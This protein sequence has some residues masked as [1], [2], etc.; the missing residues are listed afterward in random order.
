[1]TT[2]TSERT[3]AAAAPAGRRTVASYAT[4]QEAE[5]A[6]D[7]LAENGFPV[8]R[9]AI[10]GRELEY[11]EQVTGKTGYGDAAIRGAVVG[12]LTGLL[13]GWLFALFNW[14]DP[15]VSPGWLVIDGLW[16]GLV[17]GA[18]SGVIAHAILRGRR[19]FDSVPA[20]R[21]GSYEVI[22]DEEVADEAKRLLERGSDPVD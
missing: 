12:G 22:A 13:I 14:F 7:R 21:A 6:V 5:R 3:N 1:M 16:F 9:V 4:Y 20:M 2:Q 8:E 19:A 15:I 10:I 11:V 18:L 17:A